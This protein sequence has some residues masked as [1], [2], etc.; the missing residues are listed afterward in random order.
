MKE[1]AEALLKAME[2]MKKM[3]DFQDK[4]QELLRLEVY[5]LQPS[6]TAGILYDLLVESLLTREGQDLASAFMFDGYPAYDNEHPFIVTTTDSEDIKT[7][8]T[9][10]TCG[11]MCEFLEKYDY[12][13]K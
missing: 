8:H 5:E 2:S 12:F 6:E 3:F 7:T 13:K 11:Q 4:A 10:S 1:K 9:I